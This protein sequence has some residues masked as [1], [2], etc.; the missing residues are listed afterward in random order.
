MRNLLDNLLIRTN[1]RI[2]VTLIQLVISLHFV[3]VSLPKPCK[4]S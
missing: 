2:H 3:T 4:K 1:T